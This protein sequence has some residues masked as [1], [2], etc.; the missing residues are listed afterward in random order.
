MSPICP[1][2]KN[3]G[4]KWSAPDMDKA[5]QLVEESGTKGQTVA[6]VA[7]DSDRSRNRSRL[8]AERAQR[9]WL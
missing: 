3:P 6:I 1:Y 9:A 7:E 2:T 4:E 8:S 5:K